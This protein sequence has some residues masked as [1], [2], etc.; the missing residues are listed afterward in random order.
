MIMELLIMSRRRWRLFLVRSL[1][2]IKEKRLGSG[3]MA[4]CPKSVPAV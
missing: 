3:G 1:L 2:D 4:A